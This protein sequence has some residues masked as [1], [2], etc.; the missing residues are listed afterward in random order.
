MIE[1]TAKEGLMLRISFGTAGLVFAGVLFLL[2]IVLSHGQVHKNRTFRRALIIVILGDIISICDIIFRVYAGVIFPPISSWLAL[3]LLIGVFT[4]NML[5]TYYVSIYME[6]FF[7]ETKFEK[8]I[9]H[10]INKLIILAGI[11]I[12]CG[13][14]IYR[15]TLIN[16]GLSDVS[17]NSL[18]HII[19]AYIIE[20]YFLVYCL[21]LFVK[22]GRDL[23]RRS[24]FTAVGGFTVAIS[25]IVLEFFNPTGILFNYFGSILGMHIFYI[26]VEIPDYKN[27]R[28]SIIELEEAKERADKANRAKSDFLA[29]MSHEIRTPIN[30]VLGMNEMIL[31]KSKDEDILEY[32]SNVK[33]SGRILLSLIN[34]ILDFS[35]IEDGKMDIVPAQYEV[36]SLIN[37]LVNTVSVRADEKGLELEIDIDETIPSV[38]YGDDVRIRQV[39]MNILSN[40]VKYTPK[41]KVIFKMQNKSSDY[42]DCVLFVTVSD[43]GIGIKEEDVQRLFESFVRLDENKNRNIEG[44]GLGMAIVMNLL[45]MMGSKLDVRSVYGKGSTFSFEIRQKI[46]DDTPIGDY[47]NRFEDFI[48]RDMKQNIRQYTRADILVV[49]DNDMNLKVARNLF[50]LCGVKT[51]MASSGREAI[52]M[53]RNKT[54]DMVFLDHMMPEMNGIET[55]AEIKRQNLLSENIAM[56]A[57]TANA[58]MGAREEYLEA[59]FDD[60]LTKPVELNKL[61]DMLSKFCPEAAV[62]EGAN[63][64]TFLQNDTGDSS[65]SLVTKR[66]KDLGYDMESA[67]DFCAGDE[68]FY[69]ELLHDYINSSSERKQELQGFLNNGDM[70]GFETS[71][72]SLKSISKM[73]GVSNLSEKAFDLEQASGKNDEKFVNENYP[74]FRR[75]YDRVLSDISG[76]LK[77]G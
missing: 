74:E 62:S 50:E 6:S 49:D 8:R 9:F 33:S 12:A 35:K 13:E 67:L 53:M 4:V 41:C 25:G 7:E 19:I 30:A 51:D 61:Q 24:F 15:L 58:V 48:D 17:V 34:D 60:Y 66:M 21:V 3:L 1:L 18:I 76:I 65:G 5:L 40:A 36:T 55:L 28:Q 2:E 69:A 54:Y 52:E 38:L 68:D 63:D 11:I 10:R 46:I 42:G 45:G 39:I 47:G 57:L 43:T 26:G 56:V 77:N 27:L 29:N 14:Y 20:V 31:H 75:E 32:S 72:H 73:L 64:D 70:K 44:T 23:N 71:I 22:Y 16:K 59:G 37:D